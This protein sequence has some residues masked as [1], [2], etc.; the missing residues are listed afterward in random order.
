M[1]DM[2]VLSLSTNK[3]TK[4]GRELAYR[5]LASGGRA[6]LFKGKRIALEVGKRIIDP[7]SI[8]KAPT[9]TLKIAHASKLA[10]VGLIFYES[11]PM[12]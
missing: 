8:K 11:N 6:T 7:W 12:H 3:L 10:G 2:E 9:G 5:L 4:K 1:T